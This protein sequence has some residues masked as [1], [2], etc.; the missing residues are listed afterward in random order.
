MWNYTLIYRPEEI[1]EGSGRMKDM[2]QGRTEKTQCSDKYDR[3][4]CSR[5]AK[6]S[7]N[8]TSPCRDRNLFLPAGLLA[9][10]AKMSA[11]LGHFLSC[12]NFSYF[13]RLSSPVEVPFEACSSDVTNV[14]VPPACDED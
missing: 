2:L 3:K 7:R 6:I 5:N 10:G 9:A 8:G 12:I 14:S 13:L 4:R 11:H 1:T